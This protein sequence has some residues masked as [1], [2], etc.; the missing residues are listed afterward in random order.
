MYV[1]LMIVCA[2]LFILA[3]ALSKRKLV[4]EPFFQLTLTL[5][6]KT[7]IA[8]K[9]KTPQTLEIFTQVDD[10]G[11][12]IKA[13]D[14]VTLTGRYEGKHYVLDTTPKSFIAAEAIVVPDK[15]VEI[16]EDKVYADLPSQEVEEGDVI[17]V[18][19]KYAKVS[20][21]I[22]GRLI[23]DVVA[24]L[25]DPMYACVGDMRATDQDA[26]SYGC[27]QWVVQCKFNSECSANSKCYSGTCLPLLT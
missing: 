5:D 22:A 11:V 23:A 14:R 16:R 1:P 26:C 27:N 6:P 4:M 3:F 21:V 25:D 9:E 20:N 10:S 12:P 18:H 17:F 19:N 13:G 8:I 2:L 15:G 24:D 7:K